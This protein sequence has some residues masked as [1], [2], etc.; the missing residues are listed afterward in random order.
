M[1][2]TSYPA[3]CWKKGKIDRKEE[4]RKE[5]GR[6]YNILKDSMVG[7]VYYAALQR[8]DDVNSVIFPLIVLTSV[9]DCEFYYKDMDGSVGPCY[10]DCSESILKLITSHA[11]YTEQWIEQCRQH[12]RSKRE[13][14]SLLR[15]AA[16]EGNEL[17]VTLPFDTNYFSKGDSV[18]LKF[19][20]N[21]RWMVKY[22]IVAFP[23]RFLR[24][25]GIANIQITKREVK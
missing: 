15:K 20:S 3:T 17:K 8:K 14:D 5:F 2:W 25:I 6:Y 24:K 22:S 4:C 12:H 21:N 18:I 16:K 1:G 7:S 13:F 23:M 19:E 11:G 10:Y 9:Q